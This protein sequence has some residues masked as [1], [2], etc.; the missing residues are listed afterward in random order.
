MTQTAPIQRFPTGPLPG[1]PDAR[2]YGLP[3]RVFPSL[4][5]T[6]Y[7]VLVGPPQAPTYSA[8][9]DTGSGFPD[10]NADL[11]AGFAALRAQGEA[12]SLEGLSRIVVT[13]GHIDHHGGLDY[14]RQFSA[15]PL[16]MHEMDVPVVER[17]QERYV[18]SVRQLRHFLR[19]A[20][21]PPDEQ[22]RLLALYTS[23]KRRF[24]GGPVQHV[25][26]HGQ[27]LDG[28]FTVL[29]T[30]GHCPGMVCLR[31]GS[32]LLTADQLLA[33]TMPHLSP[34]SIRPGTGLRHYLSSLDLLG[35]QP[36]VTLALGGHEAPMPDLYARV[37]AVQDSHRRKLER[38]RAACRVP[39]GLT[40]A[41]I[42]ARLYPRVS[43]YDELLA[44][45]K[46]GALAE[47]LNVHGDLSVENLDQLARDE[48][49]APRYRTL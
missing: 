20:G 21:G 6:A 44:L 25:L 9:I 29:H 26:H 35:Q 12:V 42:T 45:E 23:G 48:R 5:A 37:R 2:L 49:A 15:A 36:G 39:A 28:L 8:L 33:R 4:S 13:H 46:V 10:S 18:L 40:L 1:H 47:Y 16:A 31:L 3:L 17:W 14:V 7:V 30:P 32:V 11:A 43:G 19:E 27:L 38:V 22:A 24:V 34:E 41:Q